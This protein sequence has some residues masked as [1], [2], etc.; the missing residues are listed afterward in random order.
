MQRRDFIKRSSSAVV[1]AAVTGGTGW[2]FHNRDTFQY[3]MAW[4]HTTDFTVPIDSNLPALV[5]CRH[6]DHALALD[7]ALDGIGG[8]GRFIKTGERVTIK[9]NVGWD[10]TPEQAAN[11][12]PILVGRMVEHC[13]AAG[14]KEVVVTDVTCNDPRRCFLRSGIRQAAEE[15][16]ASVKLASGEDYVTVDLQGEL[17]TTWPVLKYFVDTDR[18]INMPVVKQHSLSGCTI[19]MKN[20][21][22]I[23]GGR[24]H[25]LHQ[26]IDQSIV[27]LATFCKPTLTV[28]DATHVLMRNG[29]QGGSLA[30]VNT[31][32]VVIC[33][34]DQVAADARAVE[35]LGR[36][37]SDIGHIVLAEKSGLG[38]LDYN[39]AGYQDV[40]V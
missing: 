28:V 15:A 40:T 23:I 22:G 7:R 24:R 13:L 31:E 20:F 4:I 12:N 21:Y 14:A 33:A 32:N 1:L 30:D 38:M 29:P 11:T 35:F 5:S 16:G 19:G 2:I 17:L 9:P 10:R 6:D 18:V 27:D 3:E 39:L 8:I 25:Q 37:A 34:T 26:D 36:S